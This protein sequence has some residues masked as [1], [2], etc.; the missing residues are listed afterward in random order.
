MTELREYHNP[1]MVQE[2]L[3]GLQL[4]P[5]GTYV[6]VTFGGGG[7]SRAILE[8]LGEGGKL[9]AFDQDP[10]ARANVPQDPRFTLI[11]LNFRHLKRGLRMYGVQHVD[12]LL[13][14]LGVSSHQLDEGTRGFSLRFNGPLDMRMNPAQELNAESILNTWEV[15][16]LTKVFREL[17]E[18]PQPHRVAH[19][20]A[21]NRPLHTTEDLVKVLEPLAPRKKQH[22][23]LAQA[24]QAI[25]L[26][27]NDE[28]GALHELLTQC[29]EVIRPAGRLVV[30]TYHSLEDRPVKNYIRD[31]KV[32]GEADRDFY[33]VRQVPFI[34]VNRKP[35]LP[36][37]TE[38][39]NNNRS[40][41]AKLRIAE[42]VVNGK[43]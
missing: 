17:G 39:M 34:A 27:V 20:I 40:R 38:L 11:P 25:R 23:F 6:D 2:C 13:A 22:Q 30:L 1:V 14:D 15:G 42:R 16:E 43:N 31:G 7:H 26:V 10:D 32:V 3:D 4:S 37:E 29:E 9:Y 33:G 35:I 12:G 41:S 28:M 18:L 19:A 24:F 8:K 21:N 5:N 36:T